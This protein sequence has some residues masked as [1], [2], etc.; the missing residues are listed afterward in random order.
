MGRLAPLCMGLLVTMPAI[1]GR[2]KALCI[3]K[4]A[5]VRGCIRWLE[6]AVRGKRKFV[7]CCNVLRVAAALRG[8]IVCRISRLRRSR[9]KQADCTGCQTNTNYTANSRDET[10]GKHCVH[11][12][13]CLGWQLYP[14]QV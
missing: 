8:G 3:D 13:T 4:L 6:S 1:L 5:R 2:R 7:V 11:H 14:A 9:G 12:F 10:M